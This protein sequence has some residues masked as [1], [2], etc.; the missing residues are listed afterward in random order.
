MYLDGMVETDYTIDY[1]TGVITF[2]AAP[3]LVVTG[4][5]VGTGVG[6]TTAFALDY[7]PVEPNSETIYLN[8]MPIALPYT[9]TLDDATGEITFNIAPPPATSITADYDYADDIT[10]DYDYADDITADYT[11]GPNPKYDSEADLNK[12]GRVDMRDIALI[13]KNWGKQRHYPRRFGRD[14][15]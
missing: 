14:Y 6:S 9:Y 3:G 12:D 11:W 5:N 13:A 8:G 10:A 7:A 2:A 15:P 1:P 4:E